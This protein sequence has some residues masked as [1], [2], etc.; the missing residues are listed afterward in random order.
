MGKRSDFEH[1]KDDDYP[2][3]IKGVLPVI[4]LLRAEGVTKLAELCGPPDSVLVRTLNA[5]GFEYVYTNDINYGGKCALS[6]SK[7]ELNGAQVIAT[8]PPHSRPIL[9]QMILHFSSM[10]PTWLLLDSDWAQTQQA[11]PYLKYCTTILPVGRIKWIENS[12]HSGK[13]N[14][15]WHRFCG[16]H[17]GP[18]VL[19]P[20]IKLQD[21]P[22]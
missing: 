17:T 6:C 4:P 3:P 10:L 15:G 5:S 7:A 9:H 14:F 2:T 21:L 22:L 20:Y 11:A 8:N 19:L 16:N 12:K 18:T 1:R 13:D